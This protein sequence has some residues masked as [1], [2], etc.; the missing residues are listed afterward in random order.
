MVARDVRVTMSKTGITYAQAVER[1]LAA[2]RTVQLS[3]RE[4]AVSRENKGTAQA[5]AGAQRI[6]SSGDQKRKASELIVS[7][8]NSESTR[9]SGQRHG[10]SDHWR[11][12]PLC[13]RCRRHHLGAYRPKTCL[14]CGST[15]HLIKDC[16]QPTRKNKETTDIVAT[17]G[18]FTWTVMEAKDD[19]ILS[20]GEL[21]L[22]N[23]C[24]Q[25]C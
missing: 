13:E 8:W 23:F 4:H 1:A 12:Y 22:G 21:V 17:A 11:D 14:G 2:E 3:A 19:K 7:V 16:L 24:T 25:C 20:A 5:A 6:G 9:S 15:G 18:M 10:R